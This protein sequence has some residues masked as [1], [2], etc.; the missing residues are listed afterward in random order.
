MPPT[1]AGPP[2]ARLTAANLTAGQDFDSGAVC[3]NSQKA[4]VYIK[5]D[6]PLPSLATIDVWPWPRV[7]LS[8]STACMRNSS[9]KRMHG[10][11]SI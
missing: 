5:S 8:W 11:S 10:S 3:A 1:R 9:F 6:C 4:F 7:C 2:D